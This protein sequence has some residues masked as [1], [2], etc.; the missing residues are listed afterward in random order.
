[1]QPSS[2]ARW[3]SAPASPRAV[4]ASARSTAKSVAAS[5]RDAAV[6]DPDAVAVAGRFLRADVCMVAVLLRRSCRGS[7]IER[8][9]SVDS[10]RYLS[11]RG[12]YLGADVGASASAAGETQSGV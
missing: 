2:P 9:R 7:G 4:A 10:R 6:V 5:A 1:M 8:A 11:R 3:V 12:R